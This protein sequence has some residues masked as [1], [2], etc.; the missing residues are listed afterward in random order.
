MFTRYAGFFF[1]RVSHVIFLFAVT[2]ISWLNAILW[3]KWGEESGLI[4][5]W[6]DG[7][8]TSNATG[9]FPLI[10]VPVFCVMC[11][12][13]VWPLTH[14][15][16]LLRTRKRGNFVF[17]TFQA[18][19]LLAGLAA[20]ET[21]AVAVLTGVSVAP[22]SL[23]WNSERSFLWGATN[24]VVEVTPAI[25]I[26]FAYVSFFVV[27]LL[28]GNIIMLCN[29]IFNN[30]VYAVV[31]IVVL[32]AASSFSPYKF[33]SPVQYSYLKIAYPVTTW[34]IFVCMALVITGLLLVEVVFIQKK[35]FL[36]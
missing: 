7:L 27:F 17:E 19:V 22:V 13:F 31:F 10:I 25:V 15:Q 23:N 21:T 34:T 14:V 16:I 24:L 35:D 29:I 3:K 2:S 8:I 6:L 33:Y 9:V 1:T 11:S 18:N 20:I 4:M 28:M 26:F 36:K 12:F 5:C 30:P 32:G